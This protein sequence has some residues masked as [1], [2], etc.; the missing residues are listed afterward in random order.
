MELERQKLKRPQ[1][2]KHE[3]DRNQELKQNQSTAT[4]T[5]TERDARTTSSAS[6]VKKQI[7]QK[8]T[9]H[10]KGEHEKTQ[11]PKNAKKPKQS[12][13]PSTIEISTPYTQPNTTAETMSLALASD[14]AFQVA[15]ATIFEINELYTCACEGEARK[16]CLWTHVEVEDKRTEVGLDVGG[17]ATAKTWEKDRWKW[18]D[19]FD[20]KNQGK[21]GGKKEVKRVAKR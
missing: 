6:E 4:L 14:A 5:P 20:L 13:K 7:K 9:Q 8:R 2:Q 3:Q 16:Y 21:R 15:Q 17:G 19:E 11:N 10:Q 12:H 1:Q 18:D